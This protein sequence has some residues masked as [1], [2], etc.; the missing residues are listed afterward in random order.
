MHA[1]RWVAL[2]FGFG[3]ALVL[4][5]GDKE[6]L[7]DVSG[8]VK[9]D[10]KDVPAGMVY[11]DPDASAGGSG[12]QGFAP[13]KDGKF[14]TAAGGQGVKGGAYVIR[15]AVHD[16]KVSNENPWGQPLRNEYEFKKVLPKE[17]TALPIDVPKK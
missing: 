13:V 1:T 6:K 15:V 11:F 4:G 16:G 5:C 17:N 2:A 10:G 3:L 9:Y 12:M 8:T 14:D 7:Y